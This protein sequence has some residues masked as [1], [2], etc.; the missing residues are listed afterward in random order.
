MTKTATH[1]LGIL[2]GGQLGQMSAIA[3]KKLGIN[4]II[5][6]PEENSPAS[7]VADQT[8]VAN[9]TDNTAL[10]RF[11]TLCDTITYEFENIPVESIEHLKSLKPVYPD[12]NLLNISQDRI[13]EKAFLNEIGIPTT[14]WAEITDEASLKAICEE[15]GTE[16]III[17]T[18]RFGYDGKG[19]MRFN[20]ANH[21]W[22]HVK[23]QLKGALIAEEIINF[24]CE[25]ST[26]CARDVQ[27]TT[28]IYGP[29]LNDHKNHI[30]DTTTVPA[31]IDTAIADEAIAKTENLAKAIN[32]TGILTVEFFVTKDGAL[33]A[34]EIAPRTHNSGHWSIDA[35][36]AS[37]FENHVRTTCEMPVAPIGQHSNAKMLNL[38]GDDVLTAKDHEGKPDI[39]VHLYGKTDIKPGRKMGHINFLKK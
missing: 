2:G 38:I 39:F 5:F 21:T 6:T 7:Q 37:Q 4:T 34:N 11:A 28:A 31:T 9:Y 35:C 19:Q 29:M 17:K 8:I 22:G 25:I 12:S 10:E 18:S 24:S 26:I 1:T 32:L 30:L 14:R 33:L 36:A 3:A 23:S 27:G 15:W 20:S 13:I 16:E